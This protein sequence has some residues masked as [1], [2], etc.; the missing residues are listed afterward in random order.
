MAWA[1]TAGV[2][3]GLAAILMP[4]LW[5]QIDET[6]VPAASE[7]PPLPS[8]VVVVDDQVACGSGGCWRALTLAGVAAR[9]TDELAASLHLA[10]ETCA[11]RSLLDR[12]VVC[13]QVMLVNE[14]A[15]VHLR[16]ERLP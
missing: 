3:L 15:T 4:V 5:L 6:A 12:R 7:A 2:G 10:Q 14:R 11:A 8:G 1:A 13:T 16:F 9:S